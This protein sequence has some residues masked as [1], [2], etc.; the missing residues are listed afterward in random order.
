MNSMNPNSVNSSSVNPD[1]LS[2]L[3][4][5]HAPAAISWWPLAIGWW[6]VIGLF[7]IAIAGFVYWFYRPSNRLRRL[8]LR[9]LTRIEKFTHDDGLLAREVEHLLRRYALTRFGREQV[10]GLSGKDWIAFVIA[11]GGQAWAGDSG[12][13]LLQAAYGGQVYPDRNNWLKGARA[14]IESKPVKNN[15]PQNS[16]SPNQPIQDKSLGKTVQEQS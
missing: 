7:V 6:I 16:A 1:W 5:A 10:A 4:P 11:H 12:A 3:A 15:A 13:R 14:F 8:A 9:E 2:Q